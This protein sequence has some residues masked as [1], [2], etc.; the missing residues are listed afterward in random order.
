[1]ES[2]QSL[3][4]VGLG[5]MIL[6][7]IFSKMGVPIAEGNLEITIITLVKIVG[8][9]TIWYG[10]FRQGDITFWGAKYKV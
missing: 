9:I 4:M 5:V 8:G 2:K 7:F 10:R 6:G 3:T 1:M